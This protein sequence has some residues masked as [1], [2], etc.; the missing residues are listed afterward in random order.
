[1]SDFRLLETTQFQKTLA[2]LPIVD[3]RFIRGKLDRYIYPQLRQEPFFGRNIKKLRGYSPDL[4][5]YRIGRYR[6][7]YAVD[8]AERIVSLLSIDLRRDAYR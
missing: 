7:F 3:S 6:V 8:D 5:R 2:A 1:L 4:W